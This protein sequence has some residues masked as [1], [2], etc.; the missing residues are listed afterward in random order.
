MKAGS[1]RELV[2][3][4]DDDE[5]FR[6]SLRWL[7][8]SAGYR[9]VAFGSAAD[10]LQRY[11]ADAGTCLVLDVRMPDSSG[12]ELQQELN[13]RGAT[14]PIVFVTGHGDVAMAVKALKSGAFD[15]I[16]KPFKDEA[17]L[18]LIEKAAAAH[19]AARMRDAARQS[20]AARL[21]TLT[22]REREIL[23]RVIA[24]ERN[25]GI[26]EE[27]GISV[28]TVEIH[29]SRVMEKMG[30]ESLAAL[31]KMVAPPGGTG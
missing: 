29:R 10:F 7:L 4:V 21:A 3:V 24:G 31:V 2:Y 23:D 15:F 6:D 9:V 19:A 26:A 25:K 22:Q 13:R 18:A 1:D 30:A 27:L 16:E 11:R 17:L 5:A 14:L 20:T 8:E 12:L 28:K